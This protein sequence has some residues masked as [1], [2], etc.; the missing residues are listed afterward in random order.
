MCRGHDR[1]RSQNLERP[2]LFFLILLLLGRREGTYGHVRTYTTANG[3]HR[4]P[5]PYQHL[6]HVAYQ[7]SK[8]LPGLRSQPARTRDDVTAQVVA[9]RRGDSPREPAS[10]VRRRRGAQYPGVGTLSGSKPTRTDI[11]TRTAARTTPSQSSHLSPFNQPPPCSNG[12]G[13][14]LGCRPQ[15]QS[16][17]LS[18]HIPWQE[19]PL[20]DRDTGADAHGWSHSGVRRQ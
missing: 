5:S 16:P 19:Q 8:Q 20:A 17:D 18:C 10:R 15:S 4:G 9:N 2:V 11:P 3:L 13:P 7:A 1:A 14:G 12:G 6:H